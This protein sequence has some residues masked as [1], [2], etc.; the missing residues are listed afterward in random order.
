MFWV[1]SK[2]TTV[3]IQMAAIWVQ[4]WR[5][6]P[7]AKF[8][9]LSW[10]I[11]PKIFLCHI[12]YQFQKSFLFRIFNGFL[13]VSKELLLFLSLKTSWINQMCSYKSYD[14]ITLVSKLLCKNSLENFL[15]W[16]INEKCNLRT[17][18]LYKLTKHHSSQHVLRKTFANSSKNIFLGFKNPCSFFG[19]KSSKDLPKKFWKFGPRWHKRSLRHWADQ[20]CLARWWVTK[21]FL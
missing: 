2:C 13:S 20:L 7:G 11:F 3:Y 16:H 4:K 9:K 17:T 15:S 8:S 14:I 19:K 5:Q 18:S 6:S 21:F 1:I 10:D 12:I